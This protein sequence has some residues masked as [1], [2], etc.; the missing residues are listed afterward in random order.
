MT[1]RNNPQDATLRNVRAAQRRHDELMEILTAI[2]GTV[3]R[4]VP[5]VAEIER[6]VSQKP[7]S[8]AQLRKAISAGA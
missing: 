2:K 1:K 7:A 3:N 4:L 6:R 5:R 8:G